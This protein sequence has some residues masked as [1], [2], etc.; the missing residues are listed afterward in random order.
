MAGKATALMCDMDFDG[1][2]WTQFARGIGG[3]PSN[4]ACWV[5][6]GACN[7]QSALDTGTTFRLSDYQIST[8]PHRVIRYFTSQ[9]II[10]KYSNT[11]EHIVASM[12]NAVWKIESQS[13]CVVCVW[14]AC[15][16]H[17]CWI[18]YSR[19]SCDRSTR[20]TTHF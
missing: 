6:S 3:G 17:T 10:Y 4:T 9:A 7:P 20:L 16:P 11:F 5:Q 12:M 13:A 2:G 8:I 1:G 15:N 14:C 18:W 19:A